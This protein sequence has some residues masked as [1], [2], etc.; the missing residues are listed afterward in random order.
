MANS[1]PQPTIIPRSAWG[2]KESIRRGN[3]EFAPVF[4]MFVHHTVTENNDPN[5]MATIRGIYEYHVNGNGWN[6]IG[7]NFLIDSNGNI[8]EGRYS[9]PYATGETPTSEDLNGNGTVGAHASG[10]NSG[11]RGIALLGTFNDV[12]PSQAQLNS[13]ISMFAWTASRHNINPNGSTPIYNTGTNKTI[14]PPNISGHRDGGQTECPG[15]QT[16]SKLPSIRSQVT[17]RLAAAGTSTP[18]Y[19][20]ATRDGQVLTFGAPSLGSMAGRKLNQPIVGMVSTPSGNG[21]QLVATDGGIF[22]YGDA[23]FFGSMGGKSLNQAMVGMATTPSGAGYWTVASDGGIFAF[24]DAVFFGSMG[25]KPLNQPIVGMAATPT[26]KGYWLVASD[27]GIFAYGDAKFFGST[28]DVKLVSPVSHM[29]PTKTGQGYYLVSEDG[30]IFAYG[31][32]VYRGGL[33]GRVLNQPIVDMTLTSTGNGYFLFARDGGVFTYG[34]A[35][36]L[37]A[38]STLSGNSAAVA[39]AIWSPSS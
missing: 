37:G 17:A 22:S 18:G 34:D 13:L 6:D 32:A 11:S 27:G 39:G 15:D 5:P 8:Y 4:K 29:R 14:T 35:T 33:G 31:D 25:G 2:A 10:L 19:W 38:Q 9:R 1:V 24:G 30:G 21:Y 12:G 3:P 28:G 7:Y 20:L 16:Y 26:G 36:F 23:R